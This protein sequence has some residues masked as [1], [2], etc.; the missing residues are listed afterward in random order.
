MSHDSPLRTERGE[1]VVRIGE[2]SVVVAYDPDG[3][4]WFVR[5]SSVA[6][7]S[8]QADTYD[9]LVQALPLLIRQ[10]ELP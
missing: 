4:T 7:L 2:A 10:A 6:G 5:T 1:E 8:A 9:E 3:E